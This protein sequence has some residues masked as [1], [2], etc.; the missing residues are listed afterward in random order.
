MPRISPAAP[1]SSAFKVGGA[2][3]VDMRKVKARKD[4]IVADSR[5]GLESWLKGM[6]NCTIYDGHARFESAKEISVGDEKITADKIFINVGARAFVPPMPGLDEIEYFTNSTLLDVDFIPK[7]LI[8]VG[9]SYIGLEF[10]QMFPPFRKRSDD[11]RN[12]QAFDCA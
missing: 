12:G 10:G 6:E 5:N 3:E 11:Y 8:I 2:V 1:P 7:H 4:Q 9:G